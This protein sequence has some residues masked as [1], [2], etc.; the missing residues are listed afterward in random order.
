[1]VALSIENIPAFNQAI[2]K[3]LANK[4]KISNF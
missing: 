3:A 1:M 2:V 4:P